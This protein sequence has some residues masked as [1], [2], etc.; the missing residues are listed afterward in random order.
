MKQLPVF[1]LCIASLHAAPICELA[2]TKEET[3]LPVANKI[4]VSPDGRGKIQLLP[5]ENIRKDIDVF[6]PH[7]ALLFTSG[8]LTPYV[9]YASE[10]GNLGNLGAWSG[11]S[12]YAVMFTGQHNQQYM[13]VIYPKDG[14]LLGKEIDMAPLWAYGEKELKWDMKAMAHDAI[15]EMMPGENDTVTCLYW[16][17]ANGKSFAVPVFIKLGEKDGDIHV[18]FVFGK[19]TWVDRD[20]KPAPTLAELGYK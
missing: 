11:S 6:E 20:E 10:S 14:A 17:T 16:R 12:R 8:M 18:E 13:A 5:I 2:F 1:L 3:A 15:L 9:A 19:P 7:R 4:I